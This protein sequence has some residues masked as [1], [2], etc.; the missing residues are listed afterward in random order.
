MMT[1]IFDYNASKRWTKPYPAH[2][3]GVYPIANGQIYGADMPVEESGNMV[4]LSAT[5]AKIE[6]N[7][8]YVKKYWDLLTIWTNYL[9]ENGL[10]PENQLC[11]DDFAGHWAHNANLSLK[12]IMGITGYS[13]MAHM[14]GM[15]DVADKYAAIAKDMACNGKAWPTKV[16]TIVWLS[17]AKIPGAKSTT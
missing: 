17:T 12:A 14:L 5:I 3:L 8:N 4:I 13:E 16:I 15:N 6:G 10:D 1:S 7:A 2:D 11:T 9:V